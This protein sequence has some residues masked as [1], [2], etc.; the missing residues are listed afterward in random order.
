[1]TLISYA[2]DFDTV[3]WFLYMYDVFM[4]PYF[5]NL[6]LVCRQNLHLTMRFLHHSI[7][8]P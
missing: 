8:A 7:N 2:T 4:K 1:M 5:G 6:S 3:R